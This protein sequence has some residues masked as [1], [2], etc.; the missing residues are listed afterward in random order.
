[1]KKELKDLLD[2]RIRKTKIYSYEQVRELLQEL[3]ETIFKDIDKGD[4]VITQPDFTNS[5][6]GDYGIV[7]EHIDK[8]K[9]K[10]LDKFKNGKIN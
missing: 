10:Y 3:I 4:M 8:I 1:M 2:K 7:Y 6:D 9:Q 5:F